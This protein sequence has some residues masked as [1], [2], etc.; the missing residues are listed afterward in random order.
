MHALNVAKKYLR[1]DI[2]AE[3]PGAAQVIFSPPL[4]Y[5]V[6]VVIVFII[7]AILAQTFK[8]ELRPF[9]F[10]ALDAVMSIVKFFTNIG[11]YTLYGMK[12][13]AYPIKETCVRC[14]DRKGVRRGGAGAAS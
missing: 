3:G 7:L 1:E 5:I 10:A 11:S 9:L 13:V 12:R 4:V 14:Y 2:W 8:D 6:V